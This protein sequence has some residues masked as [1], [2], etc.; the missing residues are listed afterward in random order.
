MCPAVYG[1][2]RYSASLRAGGSYAKRLRGRGQ[3]DVRQLQFPKQLR[4][5]GEVSGESVPAGL[6]SKGLR[7][8]TTA[9]TTKADG[10]FSSIRAGGPGTIR[11]A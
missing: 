4:G 2:G 7:Q 10:S 6:L 11:A 1:F 9:A 8:P 5:G 3:V